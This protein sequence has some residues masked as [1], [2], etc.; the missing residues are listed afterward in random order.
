MQPW[1]PEADWFEEPY[2][3]EPIIAAISRR[4]ENVEVIR[5]V[6]PSYRDQ[7]WLFVRANGRR[8]EEWQA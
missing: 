7:T 6:I 2:A 4:F 1:R 8:S 3:A 5:R